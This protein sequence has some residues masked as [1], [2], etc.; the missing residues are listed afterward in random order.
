M[1]LAWGVTQ[2]DIQIVLKRHKVVITQERLEELHDQLDFDASKKG[3]S[4]TPT[5]T[6][7]RTR[8]CQTS[9]II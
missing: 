2:D 3:C 4:A 1:T 8:C 5:W 9:K 6:I 7:K